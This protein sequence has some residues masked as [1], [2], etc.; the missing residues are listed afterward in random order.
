MAFRLLLYCKTVGLVL[1]PPHFPR[2]LQ[3]IFSTT[4]L[5]ILLRSSG[6]LRPL[7]NLFVMYAL[8]PYTM[9]FRSC[10]VCQGIRHFAFSFFGNGSCSTSFSQSKKN[11]S[12]W[13]F[14]TNLRSWGEMYGSALIKLLTNFDV[15][16][17]SLTVEF[18]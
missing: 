4:S 7:M 5:F 2:W 11:W 12:A 6:N 15:F 3:K 18:R 17:R 16:S 1:L 14:S 9:L 8:V 10:R 13:L